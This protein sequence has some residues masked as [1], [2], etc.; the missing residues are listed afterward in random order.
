MNIGNLHS[1]LAIHARNKPDEEAIVFYDKSRTY[2]ELL[3]RVNALANLL[4]ELGVRK[5]DHIVVYM[6]N[7]LEMVEIYYAVSAAGAVAVPINYMVQGESL[8]ALINNSDAYYLFVEEETLT[9][10]K[11]AQSNLR[12]ITEKT[13]ILVSNHQMETP[14]I[15]YESFLSKGSTV[16]ECGS[17][18]G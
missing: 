9:A 6:R 4:I 7:R 18:I 15:S 11:R 2:K 8:Q 5:G 16:S 17:E 13:T 10:L 3:E 14:Y 1:G 12:T